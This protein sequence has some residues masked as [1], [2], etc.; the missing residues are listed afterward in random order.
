[1]RVSGGDPLHALTPREFEIFRLLAAGRS[2]ESIAELV[3]LSSK[4]V[5][6]Y[7]SL[8][9]QKLGISSDVELVLLAQRQRLL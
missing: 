7:H 4:T 8:I 3:S 5:S 2:V 6:N 9:K 1:L